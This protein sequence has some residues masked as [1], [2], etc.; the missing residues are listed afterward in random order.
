MDP[1][2]KEKADARLEEALEEA[3][4]RDPRDYYRDMLREL[5][6]RDPG[7]YDEAVEHFQETLTPEI[8]S[9]QRNPLEAWRE[10]GRKLAQ[11]IAEGRT[12]EIDDTGLSHPHDPSTHRDHLVVHLPDDTGEK[13]ILVSLPAEVTSAQRATY[14]LLVAGKQTLGS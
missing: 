5:K 11:W 13:A 9:G 12:V 10:Y 4:A 3:G 1:E 2:L 8:A 14:D 7:A 6:G